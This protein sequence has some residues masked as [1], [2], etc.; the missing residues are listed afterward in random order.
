MVYFPGHFSGSVAQTERVGGNEERLLR[1][2]KSLHSR[3]DQRER[4]LQGPV[5]EQVHQLLGLQS[6]EWRAKVRRGVVG[7]VAS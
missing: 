1:P 7:L 2:I 4:L 6:G 3:E 5:E